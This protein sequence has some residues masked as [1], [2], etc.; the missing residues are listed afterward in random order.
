[1]TTSPD[2]SEPFGLELAN[3]VANRLETGVRLAFTHPEYCGT[4]LG[5]DEH[6]LFIH[7]EVYD[8][9]FPSAMQVLRMEER[10]ESFEYQTFANRTDFVNWLAAQ[11]DASLS[12]H[13]L[14][15]E[16]RHDN[17]RITRQ[18]LTQF[19]VQ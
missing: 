16:W 12:G 3:A 4:G 18:R 11:S 6:G 5:H 10:G 8:G 14:P 7:A 15:H 1:M 2:P 19:I 13:H 9:E 17:Q